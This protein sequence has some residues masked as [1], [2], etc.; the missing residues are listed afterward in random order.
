[1]LAQGLHWSVVKRWKKWVFEG[2]GLGFQ[3][4]PANDLA[5][6]DQARSVQATLQQLT[7]IELPKRTLLLVKW[8]VTAE[9]LRVFSSVVGGWQVMINRTCTWE[10]APPVSLITHRLPALTGL[11]I[12]DVSLTD[13]LLLL[14][15]VY[16]RSLTQLS[17]LDVDL[18]S[19]HAHWAVER[20][21]TLSVQQAKVDTVQFERLPHAMTTAYTVQ[22]DSSGAVQMLMLPRMAVASREVRCRKQT[23]MHVLSR[24]T[25][26]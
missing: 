11:H 23:C 4:E 12:P 15:L 7:K 20:W 21:V 2:I 13:D 1:M 22:T 25:M 26:A 18:K 16:W 24:P 8:T 5:V 14:L 19:S 3:I 9:L 10:D 17:V 6:Q